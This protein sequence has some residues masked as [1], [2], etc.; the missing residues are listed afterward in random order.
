ML[1]AR[2]AKGNESLWQKPAVPQGAAARIGLAAN[3]NEI[4]AD[5]QDIT[6][7]RLEAVIKDALPG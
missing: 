1:R 6:I 7:R 3:R 5:G 4:W 2:G